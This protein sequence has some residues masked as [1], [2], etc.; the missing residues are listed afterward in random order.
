MRNIKHI[1][2]LPIIYS[3]V[4]LLSLRF[5]SGYLLSVY[6]FLSI[7]GTTCAMIFSMKIYHS[8]DI[9]KKYWLYIIFACLSYLLGYGILKIQ[10]TFF[11][12]HAIL[13]MIGYIFYFLIS[14]FMFL[15]IHSTCFQYR[16]K[17]SSVQFS[18][19]T[20]I[21]S[22]FIG[23]TVYR[24]FISNLSSVIS[25]NLID[26]C[27]ASFFIILDFLILVEILTFVLPYQRILTVP[28]VCII[29]GMGYVLFFVGHMNFYYEGTNNIYSSIKYIN[30]FMPLSFLWTSCTGIYMLSRK[31][32]IYKDN[33]S[34]GLTHQSPYAIDGAHPVL[35]IISYL[36][37][38]LLYYDNLIIQLALIIILSTRYLCNKYLKMHVKN[39]YLLKQYK[40]VNKLLKIKIEEINKLN[41][42][43]ESKVIDRTKELQTKNKKLYDMANTDAL[44]G[45]PNRRNF[46]KKLNQLIHS[47]DAQNKFALL[48][49]DLDRFKSINDLYGHKIGDKVLLE[50]ANRL[51]QILTPNDFIA[52]QSGDEFI[53]ILN[54]IQNEEH[55]QS[56]C[57]KLNK[58]F[59][60]PF[61]I[62]DYIIVSTI[63]IGCAIYPFGSLSYSELMRY[64]DI[65]LYRSKSDGRN[66]YTM[67]NSD[68]QKEVNRK[69]LIESQLFNAVKQ[70]EFELYYQP[71]LDL[72]TNKIVGL[73]A[74]IRWHNKELGFVSPSEFIHIAE[75]NGAIASLGYFVLK[76][77]CL[78]AK[79][80]NNKVNR[81]IKIGINISPKQFL[82]T[83]LVDNIVNIISTNNIDPKYIDLEITEECGIKNEE[84]TIS[85]LKALKELGITISI[86]D[87]G[88]GYSSLSYLKSYPIDTIKIAMELTKGIE[89]QTEDLKIVQAIIAM[90]NSLNVSVIAEGVET[91]QQLSILESL[92]CHK[93][94]GYYIGK[95]M[96]IDEIMPMLLH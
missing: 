61:F 90:S 64:A 83:N 9:Y 56:I 60:H 23:L 67:F 14:I 34:S 43:L 40:D 84:K 6:T 92:G 95:P 88:T 26:Y 69:M 32:E 79:E 7:L 89:Y 13:F 80:I 94:Q 71:Q 48:F 17:W 93:I 29:Y 2:V 35:I 66:K 78:K 33:D 77:A 8:L 75:E 47:G 62:D 51:R 16:N 10:S 18:I 11:A 65:A 73:E 3:L 28:K 55:V 50:V 85:K 21:L 4:Y 31:E 72:A 91:M 5:S 24:L 68:L 49:I 37:A 44:T 87:F 30:T 20:V 57:Q 86:D 46:I 22:I 70:N 41:M 82:T 52:R 76:E 12:S 1:I 19:D 53:V 81:D 38:A 96:P 58:E 39:N 59:E 54:P 63:S 42:S 74:L 36:C 45:L 27:S 15:S 25:W